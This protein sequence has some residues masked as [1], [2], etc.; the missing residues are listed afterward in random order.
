MHNKHMVIILTTSS[1]NC[2]LIGKILVI[3][4]TP[5]DYSHSN[6]SLI[7]SKSFPRKNG[8]PSNFRK[9]FY[10]GPLKFI[11]TVYRFNEE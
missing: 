5:F 10:I 4:L 3:F 9:E 6:Y 8:V 2:T 1:I 7:S 11:T